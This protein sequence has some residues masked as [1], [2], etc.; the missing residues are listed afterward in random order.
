MS[1]DSDVASHDQRSGGASLASAPGSDGPNSS[2]LA[3][4]AVGIRRC[5]VDGCAAS[6][7]PSSKRRIERVLC[8]AHVEAPAVV[9]GGRR[10]EAILPGVLRPARRGRFQ[11]QEQDVHGG[12]PA[13]EA[14][15]SASHGEPRAA[16]SG[17]KS[18][19]SSGRLRRRVR[20]RLIQRFT[21]PVPPG[22]RDEPRW[23]HSPGRYRC[24]R[25]QQAYR[26]F[27][28]YACR[29][30]FRGPAQGVQRDG[31]ENFRGGRRRGEQRGRRRGQRR[32]QRGQRR[33]PDHRRRASV[34][35]EVDDGNAARR[36]R[37]RRGKE[38]VVEG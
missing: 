31:T 17:A 11:G 13:Q 1:L 3:A 7:F 30:F 36:R 29:C 15:A 27:G 34:E 23:A 4:H 12:P 26:C 35:E 10:A 6:C 32:G 2:A 14:A 38:A 22:G 21:H 19:G 5:P 8:Q 18:G 24:F 9:F 20:A 16:E 37:R 25:G 33:R 28:G